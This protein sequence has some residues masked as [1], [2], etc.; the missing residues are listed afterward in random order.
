M[1]SKQEHACGTAILLLDFTSIFT[2]V[3]KILKPVKVVSDCI[4]KILEVTRVSFNLLDAWTRPLA[5]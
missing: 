4:K 5:S 3:P 2:D 1:P